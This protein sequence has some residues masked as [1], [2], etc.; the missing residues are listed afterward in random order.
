MTTLVLID[1]QV[2]SA[3]DAKVSVFDRG[4]L[5]GDSVFETIRTYSGSPFR[6]QEHLRRLEQSARR[7]FIDLP[8]SCEVLADEVRRAVALAGNAESYV[9]LMVTRGSGP[10]GL[11]SEFE[12]KPAR[13]ILAGPLVM[14][15]PSAYSDGIKVV[16]YRTARVVEATDAAGAKVGNY[17]VAVLAMREARQR[18]AS[19]ALIVDGSGGVAEGASSNVFAYLEGRWRTPP[20][21]VGILPGI[22][23]A[24]ILDACR[25]HG[26]PVVEEPLSVEDLTRAEEAFICSSIREIVPVVRVDEGNVGAG[27][28]GPETARLVQ[29]FHE[30]VSKFIGLARDE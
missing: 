28:P 8:V 11:D 22:T 6:L 15:P 18:G 3:E 20:L 16:T 30:E 4:F 12:A 27:R 23:R 21:S 5:Y 29:L 7:V 14:P 1:G 24:T 9:R 25:D 10:L 19:E 2:F 26:V 13:V 17:L